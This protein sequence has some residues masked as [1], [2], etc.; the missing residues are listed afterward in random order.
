MRGRLVLAR[1]T[2]F[3]WAVEINLDPESEDRVRT[4]W[5]SLDARGVDSLGSVP[6]A[7][8]RPHVSLAV[9]EDADV[10]RVSA[11][12]APVLRPCLGMPLTLAY[13]GFFVSPGAVA[14]L[15]VTPSERLLEVHRQVHA[16]LSGFTTGMWSLYEPGT[17]VPH[18]TLAMGMNDVTAIVHAI[19]TNRM[20]V[21]AVAYEVHIVE[22]SS[23]RSRARL[24]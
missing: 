14:F 19:N 1:D 4:I 12:L 2:H 20:P 24:A 18:C 22:I 7:E 10:P 15:G 23:G 21:H 3:V 13:L 9:F 16:T 6:G 8:Y 11:A 17:F 5:A